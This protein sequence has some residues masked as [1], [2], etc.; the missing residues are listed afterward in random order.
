MAESGR[1]L[2]RAWRALAVCATAVFLAVSAAGGALLAWNVAAATARGSRCP[3]PAPAS[4]DNATTAQGFPAPDVEELRRQLAEAIQDRAAV[5]RRLEQAHGAHRE[6]EGALKACEGRQSL[7]ERQLATLKAE[8]DEA[9]ARGTQIGAEN[10]E[11]TEAVA[12]W[13]AA[14]AESARLLDEAQ[15][16][17]RAAEAEGG[18][19]AA[20]E[21]TLR[22]R[23][24]ALETELD[25]ERRQSHSR[26]GSGAR[27]CPRPRPSPRT[28]PSSRSRSRS[29][30]S[31]GCQRP[32]RTHRESTATAGR[33]LSLRVAE[34]DLIA[35]IK[36][37]SPEPTRSDT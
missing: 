37:A 13:E 25:P 35:G 12:R 5:A 17:A 27:L 29:G 2:G 3:E 6:L 7:L 1:Q 11:L 18:A 10:G 14:A 4:T 33:A 31:G 9:K 15:R 8:M 20:R 16:R 28:R 34:L 30:T 22:Q 23:V 21:A 26:P 19:C 24:D 36:D 32:R